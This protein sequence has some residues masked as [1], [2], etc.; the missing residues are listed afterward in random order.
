MLEANR[1]GCGLE[2]LTHVL[3]NARKRSLWVQRDQRRFAG[4]E[5]LIRLR[6]LDRIPENHAP[7]GQ[8]PHPAADANHIIIARGLAVAD[9]D[10]G[11]SEEHTSEL[12]S[13]SDLVCRLLLEKKKNNTTNA[14]SR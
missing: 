11:R 12:Q 2:Q 8:V 6:P 3:R 1:V 13:H 7:G 10:I 5:Q 14:Q 4:G 9:V